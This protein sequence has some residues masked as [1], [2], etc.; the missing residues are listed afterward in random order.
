M[1]KGRSK[2]S[3]A[4]NAVCKFRV[5]KGIKG[6]IATM[7]VCYTPNSFDLTVLAK[8]IDEAREFV[9]A[10]NSCLMC[11]RPRPNK[12]VYR[13]W[14]DVTRQTLQ[15]LAVRLNPLCFPCKSAVHN[16]DSLLA[17]RAWGLRIAI[18][19]TILQLSDCRR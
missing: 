14:A 19:S 8:S 15:E 11:V 5:A 16:D 6:N 7:T 2:K 18:L 9:A 17:L 10:F 3:D 12:N 1:Q 4:R 13:A